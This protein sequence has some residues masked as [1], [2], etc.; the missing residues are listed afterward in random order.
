MFR[1]CAVRVFNHGFCCARVSSIGLRLLYGARFRQESTLED[2]IGSH[3]G[4]LEA[5]ARVRPMVF[6]SGVYASYRLAL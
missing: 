1:L 6:I 2:A 5:L 4:S 3:A